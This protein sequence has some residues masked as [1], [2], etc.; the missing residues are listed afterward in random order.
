MS[1]V[2]LL[3]LK[4]NKAKNYIIKLNYCL[5]HDVVTCDVDCDASAATSTCTS[6]VTIL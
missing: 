1:I 5:S 6:Q 2:I 4:V 3:R